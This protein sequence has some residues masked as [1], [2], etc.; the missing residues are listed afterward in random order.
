MKR[1][2]SNETKKIYCSEEIYDPRGDENEFGS[3][4]V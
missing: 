3:Q 1:Y 4:N 2:V